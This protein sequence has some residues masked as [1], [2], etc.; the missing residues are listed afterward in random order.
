[1]ENS[2]FESSL[3]WVL[4]LICRF[5]LSSDTGIFES[6]VWMVSFGVELLNFDFELILLVLMAFVI[7]FLRSFLSKEWSLD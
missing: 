3:Y 5:T 7:W 2:P 6:A 1:M 4:M